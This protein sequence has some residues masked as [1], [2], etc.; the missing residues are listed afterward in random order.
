MEKLDLRIIPE[1]STMT[2][3][4]HHKHITAPSTTVL[5]VAYVDGSVLSPRSEA[6]LRHNLM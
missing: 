3:K 2:T 5:K 4:E 1:L 6:I